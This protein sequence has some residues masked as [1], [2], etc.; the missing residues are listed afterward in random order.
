[1]EI[2]FV[3]S[4]TINSKLLQSRILANPSAAEKIMSTKNIAK[5]SRATQRLG[6]SL[7][8]LL[9]T[10]AQAHTV[11]HPNSPAG[12]FRL[13]PGDT[14]SWQIRFTANAVT[15]ANQ[16]L[17]HFFSVARRGNFDALSISGN[18]AE[19]QFM[20]LT[21]STLQLRTLPLAAG[22]SR[23]CSLTLSR[24]ANDVRNDFLINSIAFG[25]PAELALSSKLIQIDAQQARIYRV[26]ADNRSV[27]SLPNIPFT[28]PCFSSI[29][30][31]TP[32]GFDIDFDHPGAC[33]R[34]VNSGC[35]SF[36][37]WTSSR[38]AF[39]A[40][41]VG[42]LGT[43]TCLLRVRPLN[44]GRMRRDTV[45]LETPNSQAPGFLDTNGILR[46]MVSTDSLRIDLDEQLAAGSAV[47]TI[48]SLTVFGAAFLAL[49]LIAFASRKSLAE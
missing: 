6:A 29:D 5:V 20:W 27:Y 17:V 3:L 42:P 21:T 43:S 23:V 33:P 36:T 32:R 46:Y 22:E 38:F 35:P 41:A 30:A 15:P 13:L 48:P 9:S 28:S 19:C 24:A 31:S 25:A 18:T 12:G 7:M 4:D 40:P 39:A 44:N 47:E 10:A 34:A 8:F 14:A 45:R 26:R 2:I 49:A 16:D 11:D 37:G 1:M